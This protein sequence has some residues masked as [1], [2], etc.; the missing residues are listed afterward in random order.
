L[1]LLGELHNWKNK[2]ED[3]YKRIGTVEKELRAC[4]YVERK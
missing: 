2:E 4:E 3:K 1:K